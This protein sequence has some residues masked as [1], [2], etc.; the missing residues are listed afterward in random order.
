MRL[1]AG[2]PHSARACPGSRC[3]GRVSC[4]STAYIRIPFGIACLHPSV[5]ERP[6]DSLFAAVP[7][8]AAYDVQH[9]R[10]KAPDSEVLSV[11]DCRNH[12]ICAAE[13]SQEGIRA[14]RNAPNQKSGDLA[15]RILGSF[16]YLAIR[17]DSAWKKDPSWGVIGVQKGPSEIGVHDG[18]LCCGKPRTGC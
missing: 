14:R 3:Q 9:V 10:G 13:I 7:P 4:A 11:P 18:F 6:P 16:C 8:P 2:F 12:I 5:C 1:S 17:C 15:I